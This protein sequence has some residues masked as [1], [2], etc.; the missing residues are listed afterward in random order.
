MDEGIL[1]LNSDGS[2]ETTSTS[3]KTNVKPKFNLEDLDYSL[4]KNNDSPTKTT[5]NNT[6]TFNTNILNNI[7]A[8][9][10]KIYKNSNNT[11]DIIVRLSDNNEVPTSANI[12]TNENNIIS[13]EIKTNKKTYIID[14]P[15]KGNPNSKLSPEICQ[16]Y[17]DYCITRI[18]TNSWKF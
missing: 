8:G 4:I 16:C 7:S 13:L 12:I 6:N 5:T 17:K 15:G 11:I 10:Y 9:E 3:S 2:F 18:T 1:E 14:I